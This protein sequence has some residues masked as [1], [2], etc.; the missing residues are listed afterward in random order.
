[1]GKKNK[2]EKQREL[3]KIEP[4]NKDILDSIGSPNIWTPKTEDAWLK[5]LRKMSTGEIY[6]RFPP[7]KK[8]MNVRKRGKG[9]GWG[10]NA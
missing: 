9:S 3:T 10:K 6:R 5:E 8:P 1:M 7:L 2:K 4:I